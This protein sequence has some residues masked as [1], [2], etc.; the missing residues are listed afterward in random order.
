MKKYAIIIG[1]GN[2]ELSKKVQEALF[3]AGFSWFVGKTEARFTKSKVICLN[4][5]LAGD[6]IWGG[7]L[8][9]E[10]KTYLWPS[11][12]IENASTLDGAKKPWE[13]P[14]EGYRLVTDEERSSFAFPEQA[15]MKCRFNRAHPSNEWWAVEADFS[16]RLDMAYAVPIDYT[17]Q[18]EVVE[19]TMAE[20][21]RALGKRV[22]IIKG[23]DR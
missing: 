23:D 5:R 14:P 16:W 18:P 3:E 13:V 9:D 4:S 22:K 11:F 1:E 15:R 19:M 2:E 12:V 20:L 7:C 17:F 6:L 8:N 21:E 10:E